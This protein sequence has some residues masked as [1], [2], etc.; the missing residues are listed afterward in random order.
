MTDI[1]K[2]PLILPKF[3]LGLNEYSYNSW[4]ITHEEDLKDVF[5]KI[6]NYKE[7]DFLNRCDFEKFKKFAYKHSNKTKS[8]Y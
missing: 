7:Y 4:V 1:S 3:N 2:L 5:S 8:N 6:R